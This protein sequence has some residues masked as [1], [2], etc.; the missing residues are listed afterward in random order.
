MTVKILTKIWI[1]FLDLMIALSTGINFD[2]YNPPEKIQD[3]G[4]WASK[5]PTGRNLAFSKGGF[6]RK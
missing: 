3:V 5:M 2:H 6:E 1:A 4:P